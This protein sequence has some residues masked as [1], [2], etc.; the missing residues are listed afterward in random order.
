MGQVK[1]V[2]LVANTAFTI[3]NFR[4]ELIQ[5]LIKENYEV[6]IAC[7]MSCSLMNESNV[8]KEIET[9]GATHYSIP[10]SRIGTNPLSEIK[11][12]LSLLRL[13]RKEQPGVILNYTIKPTIYS[14]LAAKLSCR[15]K[16]FSTITGIGYIFSNES[17]KSQLLAL[18]V[19]S[20]Y[21]LALKCNRLVFFQ[22]NDDV[23][24]FKKIGLL[25]NI[26]TRIVNGSGVNFND[27]QS[28]E[29]EKLNCSFLMVGRIL[30]DKGIDEYISAARQLKKQYPEA[31]FQLLGPLDSNPMS[32][33]IADVNTWQKEGVIEYIPSTKDVRSHLDL[34]EVFVLP[35]YREG[36][37]R[38][39]LE[40]MA[41]KMPIIT[42][43]APGCKETVVDGENGF[44]VDVKNST[45]LAEAMEKFIVNKSLISKMGEASFKMAQQ[46]YDVNIVNKSI[47]NEILL[48]H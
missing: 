19:K 28:T 4:K 35:S 9:I 44:L 8:G 3:L 22:N 6:I 38:S 1:K 7:P 30:K 36:T 14:S 12:F 34:A 17:L 25:N 15:A 37:P 46:K 42:T 32:Y 47:L 2:V 39:V 16:V 20:Q 45:Q 11:L 24:L 10:L 21:W 13:Y 43:N 40:A 31:K 26:P 5:S 18:I 48:Q 23:S 27:F 33:K 41:M 29:K